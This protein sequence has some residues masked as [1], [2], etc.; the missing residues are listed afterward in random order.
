MSDA[1]DV[2][3]LVLPESGWLLQWRSDGYW[4]E[5][6]GAQDRDE[7]AGIH[8]PPSWEWA[9]WTGLPNPHGRAKGAPGMGKPPHW[10][11]T[12]GDTERFEFRFDRRPSYL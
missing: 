10:C 12:L 8:I 7:I 2:T 5:L 3:T 6:S 1:L 9:A 4:R 11:I